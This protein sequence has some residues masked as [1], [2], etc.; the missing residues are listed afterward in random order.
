MD[1]LREALLWLNDPLNWTG[2]TASRP[3]PRST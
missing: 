3:S 2:R 1:V